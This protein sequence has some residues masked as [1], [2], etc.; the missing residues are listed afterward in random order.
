[1]LRETYSSKMHIFSEDSIIPEVNINC[2]FYFKIK[3][4]TETTKSCVDILPLPITL[5]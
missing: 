4:K 5:L 2:D 1:M 3:V